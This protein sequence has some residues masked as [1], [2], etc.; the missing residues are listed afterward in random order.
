MLAERRWGFV[1]ASKITFKIS[2]L[3]SNIWSLLTFQLGFLTS[4]TTCAWPSVRLIT[5]R[6]QNLPGEF[7][8][9]GPGP[10]AYDVCCLIDRSSNP[11]IMVLLGLSHILADCQLRAYNTTSSA[12]DWVLLGPLLG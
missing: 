1:R 2:H 11:P 9:T 6:P 7:S 3:C 4:C 8:E 12:A 5:T 10:D